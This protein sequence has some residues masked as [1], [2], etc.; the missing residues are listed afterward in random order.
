[1]RHSLLLVALF[2]LA[3]LATV[4]AEEKQA[5]ELKSPP[6]ADMLSAEIAETLSPTGVKIT[7]GEK[8]VAE[9]WFRKEW[10]IKPG[11]TPSASVLYPFNQGELIGVVRFG[12]SGE[13][14]RM[15]QFRKGVYTIRYGQQ[16]VDGNHVGTS[17]TL[18]FLLL[19][20][21]K[22]DTGVANL[23]PFKMV[24]L[25]T[26]VSGSTHPAILSM[27]AMTDAEAKLPAVAHDSNREFYSLQ[28]SNPAKA[29]GE[30]KPLKIEFVFDGHS[31]E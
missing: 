31:P 1:M 15:Q 29:D 21:A 14:F 26:E 16:P 18:D 9:F 23:D 28:V 22:K 25:S 13:D 30:A 19:L 10:P 12:S 2:C 24:T 5:A 17:D 6:P 27:L 8:T 20:P 4:Y 3:P 7:E 11:F